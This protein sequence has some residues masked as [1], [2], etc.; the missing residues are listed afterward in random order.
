[1]TRLVQKADVIITALCV[2][3]ALATQAVMHSGNLST[4]WAHATATQGKQKN[5]GSKYYKPS[6]L[7]FYA[8]SLAKTKIPF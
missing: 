7:F 8:Q 1:M 4:L 2:A 5:N 3:P 6:A